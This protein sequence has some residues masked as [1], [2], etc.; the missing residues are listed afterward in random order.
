MNRWAQFVGWFLIALTLVIVTPEFDLP[1]TI[2]RLSGGTHKIPLTAF[3]ASLHSPLLPRSSHRLAVGIAVSASGTL[4]AIPITS[5]AAVSTRHRCQPAL[6]TEDS[7]RITNEGL[8]LVVRH[9]CS[10]TEK[11]QQ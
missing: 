9:H 11:Q 3:T 6:P 1:E 10:H 5:I 4:L 7:K 2:M 8:V